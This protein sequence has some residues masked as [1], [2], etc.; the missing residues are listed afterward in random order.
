MERME[1][2]LGQTEENHAYTNMINTQA[3]ELR[4]QRD[5]LDQVVQMFKTAG[6][7]AVH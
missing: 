2:V 5:S 3:G 1:R 6:K 4:E 7:E